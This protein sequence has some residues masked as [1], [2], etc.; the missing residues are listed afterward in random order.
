MDQHVQKGVIAK[1]D[2][3]STVA[4]TEAIT[5][6]TVKWYVK[7][8]PELSGAMRD[9]LVQYSGLPLEEVSNHVY[10]MVCQHTNDRPQ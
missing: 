8:V 1:T 3:A 5:S 6:R 7:D 2:G 10:Q 4:T 9:V